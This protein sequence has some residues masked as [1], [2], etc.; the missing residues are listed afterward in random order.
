MCISGASQKPLATLSFVLDRLKTALVQ[1]CV[2]VFWRKIA[3]RDVALKN[4]VGG[5]GGVFTKPKPTSAFN[6]QFVSSTY[7]RSL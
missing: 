4:N 5:I 3:R 7:D 1:A 6:R 2:F